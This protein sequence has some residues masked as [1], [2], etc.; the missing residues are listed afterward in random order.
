MP[1]SNSVSCARQNRLP[2]LSPK[3]DRRLLGYAAAASAAGVGMMVLAP[4]SLAEVVYTPANQTV[5]GSLA[6]DLNNDGITDFTLNF[7]EGSCSS[8]PGCFIEE[9]TVSPNALNRVLTTY[10][11]GNDAQALSIGKRIGREDNF[12]SGYGRGYVRMVRCKSTRTS[13]YRYG[14]W[15]GG[16][17][18]LGLSF[19]V[20]GQTHYGWARF[21]LHNAKRPCVA[22]AVLTG[23]A[24]ETEPGQPI[25]AGKTSGPDK[26]AAGHPESTLG[27][28]ALGSVGR[29]SP[30]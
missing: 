26:E 28:L 29:F 4:S 6:I 8:G 7:G 22:R 23:Y 20:D 2:N 10:G 11:G 15:V 12:G 27:V 9:F 17:A 5:N 18:Y 13:F 3:L 24:Y 25:R 30:P 21:S 16:T 14:S 1:P 19:S